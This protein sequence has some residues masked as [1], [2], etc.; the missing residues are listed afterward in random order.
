M[1]S[2]CTF[3]QEYYDFQYRQMKTFSC[4]LESLNNDMYCIFHSKDYLNDRTHPE[5]KKMVLEKLDDVV[6]KSISE[7][8]SL[9]CIGYCLPEVRLNKKFK[10]FV[11]FSDATFSGEADFSDATFSG[12]ADFSDATFSATVKWGDNKPI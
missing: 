4:G 1:T 6:N 11:Y 3:K 2:F 9:F 5:N 12:E 10:Q 8:E 7:N